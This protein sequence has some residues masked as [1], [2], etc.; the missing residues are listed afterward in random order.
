MSAQDFAIGFVSV[1]ML[2]VQAVLHN[3]FGPPAGP[4]G[5]VKLFPAPGV[6]VTGGSFSPPVPCATIRSIGVEALWHPVTTSVAMT[7]KK[8][9]FATAGAWPDMAPEAL[10][11]KVFGNVPD[12]VYVLA[13]PFVVAVSCVL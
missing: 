3:C 8:Y 5:I 12:H 10:R 9:V 11:D 2:N 1:P 13:T 6:S 7:V 4:A